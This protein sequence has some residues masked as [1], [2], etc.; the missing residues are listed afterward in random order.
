MKLT[1]YH[2]GEQESQKEKPG[3]V[4]IFIEPKPGT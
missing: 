4:T 1:A 3:A 2:P